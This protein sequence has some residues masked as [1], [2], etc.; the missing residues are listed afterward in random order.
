MLQPSEGL[1]PHLIPTRKKT[2]RFIQK[3]TGPVNDTQRIRYNATMAF[4]EAVV[5]RQEAAA[6]LDAKAETC[7]VTGVA[8]DCTPDFDRELNMH[9]VG[10]PQG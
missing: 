2:M 6:V 8:D 9:T 10:L 3:A 4:I 1:A 5:R 7:G